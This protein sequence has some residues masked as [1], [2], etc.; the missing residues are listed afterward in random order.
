MSTNAV[1]RALADGHRRELLDRPFSSNGQTLN[2]L[3]VAMAMSRRVVT[4][5]LEIL[6]EAKLVSTVRRARERLHSLN[7]ASIKEI[8]D[9]G[10]NKFERP[11]LNALSEL[12]QTLAAERHDCHELGR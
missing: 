6:E 7:P 10:I 2:E 8:A 11:R 4:N 12:K 9:R 3:C 5:H 1:F